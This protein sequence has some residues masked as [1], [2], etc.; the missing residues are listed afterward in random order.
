MHGTSLAIDQDVCELTDEPI[1]CESPFERSLGKAPHE[2]HFYSITICEVM[3]ICRDRVELAR[4]HGGWQCS[5]GCGAFHLI[6][7]IRFVPIGK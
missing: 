6:S 3:A 4:R 1:A 2:A 7:E 5:P